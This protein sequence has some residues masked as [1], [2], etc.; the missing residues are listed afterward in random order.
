MVLSFYILESYLRS[1]VLFVENAG[2]WRMV[3]AKK[4]EAYT[5]EVWKKQC[6]NK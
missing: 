1:G 3:K 6:W 2:L 4:N 5:L